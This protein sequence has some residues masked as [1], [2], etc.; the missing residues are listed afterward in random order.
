MREK[1]NI[2][3]IIVSRLLFWKQWHRMIFGYVMHFFGLLKSNNDINVL[4]WSP[5]FSR[6]AQGRAPPVNY[7]INGNNYTMKYYLT[8]DIYPK[9][10][11]FVKTI[12]APQGEKRILFAKTQEAYRKDVEH[13]FGVL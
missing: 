5:V 4:E 13:A 2:M 1:V 3:V 9:W 12:L 7:S 8:D 11:I 10:A 6:L